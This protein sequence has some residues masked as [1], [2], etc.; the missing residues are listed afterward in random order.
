MTTGGLF[1]CRSAYGKLTK[2]RET[3]QTR[4]GHLVNLLIVTS[5]LQ[6]ACYNSR[7]QSSAKRNTGRQGLPPNQSEI[8]K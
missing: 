8:L 7:L 5:G 3:L 6:I 4:E 1:V 2:C